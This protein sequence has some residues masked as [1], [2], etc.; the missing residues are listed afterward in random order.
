M[1]KSRAFL[2]S[3]ITACVFAC[4][5]CRIIWKGLEFFVPYHY[6]RKK[7]KFAACLSDKNSIARK[8]VFL[9]QSTKSSPTIVL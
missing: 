7:A 1:T 8:H 3:K 2:L 4:L 5:F 6:L 9:R